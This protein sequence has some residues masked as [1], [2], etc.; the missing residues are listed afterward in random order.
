MFICGLMISLAGQAPAFTVKVD[1]DSVLLGNYVEVTFTV[2]Q[3]PNARIEAPSFE[4]FR[5]VSGPNYAS[6]MQ[7]INGEV[8]QS[9]STSYWLEPKDVGQYFVGVAQVDTGDEMLE[10]TPVEINVF[11]NPDGVEQRPLKERSSDGWFDWSPPQ[12]KKAKP[13]KKRKVYRI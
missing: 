3:V 8:T 4:G 13:K 10:T 1:L 9:V 5:V 12:P 2:E 11:H 6:S 7:M